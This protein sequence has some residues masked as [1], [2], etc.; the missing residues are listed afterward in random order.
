MKV[1]LSILVLICTL[2][3]ATPVDAS[4]VLDLDNV[5]E[6]ALAHSQDIKMSRYD[7][8]ISEA[9]K[10]QALS[11]Y[12]PS[13]SARWNTEYVKDL[14]DGTQQ[15][16]SVGSTV[17]VQNTTYQSAFV[18]MGT[19]NIYD[20]GAREKKVFMANKDVDAKKTIY[21]QSIRD[22]RIKVLN[23]YTDMLTG[24][25]ELAMKRELLAL[26]KELALTKE[27]LYNAGRITR[28]EVTDDAVKA[29]K[30][31][32]DIDNLKLKLKTTLTDLSFLT[33]EDYDVDVTVKTFAEIEEAAKPFNPDN[34]PESR[35]YDLEIE[36]KKAEIQSLQRSLFP[37]IG[38]Y[39]NYVL[40]GS[41]PHEVDTTAEYVKPRNFIIGIA[42]TMP[43]FEG[44]KSSADIEKAK[45]EL[46][47]LKVE[48]QRKMAELTNRYAKLSESRTT[49][50]NS[51]SNQKEMLTKVEEKM[52]MAQRLIDQK[53]MEW[54]DYLTQKID[55]I[56]QK[57]E[58][59]KMVIARIAA[60]REIRILSEN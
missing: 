11:L 12:Y 47:R 31:I 53:A 10:K 46:E 16:T 42:V 48:K 56:T 49:Y 59:T 15:T 36:K 17:L 20:F 38:A 26:Y 57:F 55:L 32:D 35:T 60:A 45:L 24:F 6:K 51:V 5:T 50:K 14:S 34:T 1:L 27:R 2:A 40:Y 8:G 39:S 4:L 3:P 43:L 58:L 29:V 30:V 44:F 25:E 21:K 18:L 33:G 41:D 9:G 52:Q 28:I 54:T 13:I 7:I 23:V 19:Y 37:Q 22:T